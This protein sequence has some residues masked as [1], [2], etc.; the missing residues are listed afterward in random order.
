MVQRTPSLSAN[1]RRRMTYVYQSMENRPDAIRLRNRNTCGRPANDRGASGE[2]KR[3]LPKEIGS[4]GPRAGSCDRKTRLQQQA[5]GPQEA[6]APRGKRM[7]LGTQTQM[8]ERT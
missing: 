1:F 6:R 7:V 8:V 2:C 4:C 3:Q 5:S